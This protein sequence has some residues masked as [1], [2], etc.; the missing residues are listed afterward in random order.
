ME[1]LLTIEELSEILGVKKATLYSWTSK[2]RIPYIKL[3]EGILRF[4]ESEIQEWIL[5]KSVLPDVQ[6]RT[7]ETYQRRKRQSV[8]QG[9]DYIER[10]IQSSKEAVLGPK[11]G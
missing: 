6:S 9:K 2:K 5:K 10:I 11:R 4:R 8:S 3:S 1:K 7:P